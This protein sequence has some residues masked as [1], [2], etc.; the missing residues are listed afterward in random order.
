MSLKMVLAFLVT[1]FLSTACSPP[2]V[3]NIY[4][5]NGTFSGG[6]NVPVA[7]I[8][9]EWGG[10]PRSMGS[11]WLIDGGHGALFTAKHVTDTLFNNTIELGANECRVF[12]GGKVYTC[13]VAQVSPLIEV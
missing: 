12:L 11:A 9:A 6:L 1:G 10:K 2:P 8:V 13:I 4:R 5:K 3:E 7:L